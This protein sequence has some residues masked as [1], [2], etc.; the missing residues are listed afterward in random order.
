MENTR[1]VTLLFLILAIISSSTT[2]AKIV[3]SLHLVDGLKGN[4]SRNIRIVGGSSAM[5]TQFP[6]AAALFLHLNTGESFCGGSI[7]HANYIL[8]AAHCLDDVL[9]IEVQAGT[10]SIFNGNPQYRA[11]VMPRDI[12]QHP[13][14]DQETLIN[15]IGLIF[16]IQPIGFTNGIRPIALPGRHHASNTFI[17][18]IP[19][20][21]G[22]GRYSDSKLS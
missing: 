12:R 13:H 10:T 22:W 4:V 5:N 11:I 3:N 7:I 14:Y 17:G 19:F 20:V 9:R 6:H 21:I 15:D 18:Q 8:T 2:S 16:T 1:N